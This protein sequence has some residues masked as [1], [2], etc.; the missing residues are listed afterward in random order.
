LI[1]GVTG[2]IGAGK[3]SVCRVFR[4]RGARVLD[5]DSVGHET[6][7][8]AEVLDRLV[9]AFGRDIL[10]ADGRL[11]RPEL[12]RRAFASEASRRKLTGIVW[13]ALEERLREKVARALDASPD[14]PVVIDA[15]LLLE[16]GRTDDLV[17]C[18]VVVV[19]ARELRIRRTVGRL[20]I[21][22]EE[23]EARMA[24]Q[25]SDEEKSGAADHVIVN[26]GTEDELARRA[27]E[28]WELI[29]GKPG[30]SP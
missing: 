15:P 24:H 4:E 6:V 20:G 18:L 29:A 1:V 9:A 7:A 5:A 16:W 30:A 26:D 2:G 12:G 21:T 23:A 14:R 10:D 3:S 11:N 22:P 8:Q 25:M 28:V 27:G 17:D 19:A 13:P